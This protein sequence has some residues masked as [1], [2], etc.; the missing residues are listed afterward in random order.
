MFVRG[1]NVFPGTSLGYAGYNGYYW[2]LIGH[3]NPN[4]YGLY[5]NPGGV[6]PSNNYYRYFGF[7]LRCV[8]LGG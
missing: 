6:Y 7:P 3:S 2:S 8:A 4:A 1:G 5:F